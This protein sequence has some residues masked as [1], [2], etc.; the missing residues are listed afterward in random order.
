MEYQVYAIKDELAGTFGNLMV[1]NEKVA[2]RTVRWMTQEM[3]RADCEDKRVYLLGSY[4]N[5]TGLIRPE[6]LPRL[7][8]NLELI[9]KEQ[10]NGNQ[11]L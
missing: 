10:M 6:Q 1:I 5:E 7:I 8:Y 4:D 3:E 9:K 2:D 11:N